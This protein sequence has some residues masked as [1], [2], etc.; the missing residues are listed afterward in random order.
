LLSG[1][2]PKHSRIL[3]LCFFFSFFSFIRFGRTVSTTLSHGDLVLSYAGVDEYLQ[4]NGE[5]AVCLKKEIRPIIFNR[6]LGKHLNSLNQN[7][8]IE[9][10]VRECF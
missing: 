10:K 9:G 3:K 4:Q 5:V 1:S 6:S 2:L 7:K 8:L